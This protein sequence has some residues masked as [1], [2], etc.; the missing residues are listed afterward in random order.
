MYAKMHGVT[1]LRNSRLCQC[2]N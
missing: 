1:Y 2:K